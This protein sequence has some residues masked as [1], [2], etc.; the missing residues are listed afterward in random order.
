MYKCI[1]RRSRILVLESWTFHSHQPI[2]KVKLVDKIYDLIEDNFFY[3]KCSLSSYP[4]ASKYIK[5]VKM[6]QMSDN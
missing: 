1:K 3:N 4:L 5:H 2:F 6:T